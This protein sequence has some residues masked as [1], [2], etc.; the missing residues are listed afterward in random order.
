MQGCTFIFKLSRFFIILSLLLTPLLV[1]APAYAQEGGG[2]KL[3]DS[4]PSSDDE[5]ISGP[6]S[7][8]GEFDSGEDEAEDERFFQ[9][10]R[11]FGVGLGLGF[12]TATGNA[13]KLYQGGFPTV[14]FRLDYWFDFQFALQI[15][16][17]NSSHSYN[18]PPDGLTNVNLFRI[19]AQ[20]KYYF[21]TR[22]MSAPITF[23]GPHLIAGGGF[24]QRTDNIGTGNNTAQ[25]TS[26]NTEQAFGFNAGAGL[27][28][29]LK[30]K[31]TYLDFEAVAHFVQFP[32][33]YTTK[34]QVDGLND[35]SGT[36]LTFDVVLLWTW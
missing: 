17:Q 3:D 29:T 8:Y 15:D 34:F 25:A 30:P 35:I 2:K 18:A 1:A 28:L 6:F 5:I 24:Y 22:N 10:G 14:D 31:K 12:T 20:V 36:W 11:F 26:I 27:E 23:V 32:D 9:Y 16:V 21:D 4:K 13:G 7:D 19:M 33:S